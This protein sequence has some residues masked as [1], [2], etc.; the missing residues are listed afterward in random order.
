MA[1][2]IV[3]A[4][5]RIVAAKITTEVKAASISIVMAVKFAI[6]SAKSFEAGSTM[7]V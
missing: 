1:L 3:R 2:I 4:T 5:Q 6:I 7:A